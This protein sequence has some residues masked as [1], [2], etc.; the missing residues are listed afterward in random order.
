MRDNRR[1]LD[2]FLASVER[3]AFRMAEIAT[4]QAE[5]A[6]D[7]VQ[8]AMFGFVRRYGDKPDCQWKV[9]F[10]RVLQSRIRDWYRRQKVRRRWRVWLGPRPGAANGGED[11][12][13][14]IADP[15]PR[16]PAE[17]VAMNRSMSMLQEA[18]Q[19]LSIRQQQVFLLRAWEGLDVRATAKAM[20]CSRSSVKTHY[21]RALSALRH[22]LEGHWP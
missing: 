3:R 22:H 12:L 20:N 16:D 15:H 5:E 21:A 2:L 8:D 19:D 7:I 13:A 1:P 6:R 10:Y 18:L 11:P 9:L 14:T 4:S 17:T